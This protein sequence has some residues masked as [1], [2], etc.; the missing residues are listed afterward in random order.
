VLREIVEI[1]FARGLIKMLFCTTSVAIGLNLPVRTC[2]FT[3]VWKHDG[4]QLSI[5]QGHE[6][7]Q[8]AGRAGRLGI[9]TVGHVIHL[10]NLFNEIGPISYK[11]MLKGAPQKL[12][13]NFKISY[14]L[15]L[16]MID[17]GDT[18]FTT[19]AKRSMIQG[20][21]DSELTGLL[22]KRAE[23]EK[24]Q[25]KNA[26]ILIT[27]KTPLTVLDDYIALLA[28]KQTVVN[29]KR[30]EVE[31]AIE[32]IKTE[33]TSIEKDIL[34]YNA[35][36]L[37]DEN[38]TTVDAEIEA[39]NQLLDNNINTVLNLLE[40]WSQIEFNKETNSYKLLERGHIAK[41]I[42]EVHCI[43]FA[44][45]LQLQ[46]FKSLSV[47]EIVGVLSCFTNV[48]V[49]EE[50]MDSLPTKSNPVTDCITRINQLFNEYREM[51]IQNYVNTGM[52]Y[53]IHFD[54]I[55]YV[56]DWTDAET[57]EDCKYILQTISAEKDIFLGEFVKAILKIN[58]IS[59]ELERV[60]ETQGDLELLQKLQQIP[61][62]T[63]KFVATNQSL[64]V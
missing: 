20:D 8:A 11:T 50:Y 52:D 45:I 4:A 63:L 57:E 40:S 18:A 37:C 32:D 14:N 41:Q 48:S 26:L 19:F 24:Q 38:K 30:R 42:R 3:N 29:K 61:I 59:A 15:L 53:T 12:T 58:N 47:K 36:R 51:E 54:L 22:N 1:L 56:M 7:V 28:K 34:T 13:S 33:Y 60:A 27:I 10:N 49:S 62:K 17:N 6:Y 5:L 31:R 46:A 35:I 16:N 21:I 64:Y 23:I 39:T 25:E 44:E 43:A 9:D 55:Y 2:L